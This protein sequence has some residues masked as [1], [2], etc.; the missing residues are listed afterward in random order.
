MVFPR[1]PLAGMALGCAILSS[2]NGTPCL[3][4]RTYRTARSI[5]A[6]AAEQRSQ[7]VG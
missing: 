1:I 5:S 7:I 6:K 2:G 4:T 3:V